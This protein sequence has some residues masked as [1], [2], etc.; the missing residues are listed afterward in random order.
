M[1]AQ[2]VDTAVFDFARLERAVGELL[3][4]QRR[5]ADENESLRAQ[6]ADRNEAIEGLDQRFTLQEQCR[7]DALKRIED[8]VAQVEGFSTLAS[9]T[10]G[11]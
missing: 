4:E 9:Q 6:L 7:C 5:L 1:S 10:A 11:S 3:A 8:L 2:E